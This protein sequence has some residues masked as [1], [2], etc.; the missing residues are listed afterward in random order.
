VEELA[1]LGNQ[2][3]GQIMMAPEA[4]PDS[5]CRQRQQ[6]LKSFF[7]HLLLFVSILGLMLMGTRN[8]FIEVAG[9][10]KSLYIVGMVHLT[11]AI[12]AT[13]SLL[14]LLCIVMTC[15][16]K[17]VLF[18]RVASTGL[19]VFLGVL[20]LPVVTF[21][22]TILLFTKDVLEC[23]ASNTPIYYFWATCV[24]STFLV[25]WVTMIFFCFMGCR[26]AK[27][28]SDMRNSRRLNREMQVLDRGL[29]NPTW[30]DI[31][32]ILNGWT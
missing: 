2:V 1:N 4:A 28:I 11:I 22:S 6:V 18:W 10:S 19:Q 7:K 32:K 13:Q 14:V 16:R 30:N 15:S 3:E 29:D 23:Q 17:P 24:T 26:I 9:C 8:T 12:F 25:G 31:T 21:F 27:Q 5:K 20:I